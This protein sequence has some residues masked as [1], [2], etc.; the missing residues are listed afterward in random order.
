LARMGRRVLW[1]LR[2]ARML[3]AD[4]VQ[5]LGSADHDVEEDPCCDDE[6]HTRIWRLARG[7][8]LNCSAASTSAERARAGRP[9]SASVSRRTARDWLRQFCRRRLSSGLFLRWGARECLAVFRQV[10]PGRGIVAGYFR[11]LRPWCVICTSRG[12]V[13]RAWGAAWELGGLR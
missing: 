5:C 9:G 7:P 1:V 13:S 3:L 2:G 10:L 12:D 11:P 6:P 4:E 8:S